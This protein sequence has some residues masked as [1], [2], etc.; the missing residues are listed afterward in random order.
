[1]ASN[2]GKKSAPGDTLAVFD[3]NRDAMAQVQGNNVLLADSV[4]DI[5]QNSVC[6][7]LFSKRLK[8]PK[9]N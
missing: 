3:L 5:A 9:H 8:Q 2:I 6:R 7:C 1:M 4:S